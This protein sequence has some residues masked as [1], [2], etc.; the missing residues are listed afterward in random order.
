MH[1]QRGTFQSG[2]LVIAGICAG[3]TVFTKD[4]GIAFFL[5]DAATI[6]L[7]AILSIPDRNEIRQ[8]LFTA[9]FFVITAGAFVAPW[10]IH[11]RSLPLTTEMNY[12]GRMT[13]GLFVSRL[14][15]I[16]VVCASPCEQNVCRMA[17]MGSAM[18]DRHR[19]LF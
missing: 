14:R 13:I 12:F 2:P 9:I 8:R 10:F 4:E 16:A 18:V 3:A 7:F 1:Q 15:D 6:G 11:R 5:V 17:R 19:G